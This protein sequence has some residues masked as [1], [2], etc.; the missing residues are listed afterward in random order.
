MCQ[1][2]YQYMCQYVLVHV[3]ICV[4]IHV[5]V[6]YQYMCQYM[7][8]Y[9]CQ[10]MYQYMCQYMSPDIQYCDVS[11]PGQRGSPWSGAGPEPSY[12]VYQQG[13]PILTTSV[14]IYTYS[15]VYSI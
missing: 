2:T 11:L 8:Q 15:V 4:S 3:S 6:L 9:M 13:F 12:L 7:Y 14:R 5:S 10:Y 1:Y